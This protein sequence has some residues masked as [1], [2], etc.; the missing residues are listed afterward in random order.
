MVENRLVGIKSR[1]VYETPGGTILYAAHR[2]IE[3]LVLDRDTMHFK[4]SLAIRYAELVYNG[5]W[6]SPLREALDAFINATQRNVTGTVRLRLY[7]GN[8]RRRVPGPTN[9][10]T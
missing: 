1:G 10:S 4:E 7:K 5:Q 3:R 6:F 8:M 2:E 9:R